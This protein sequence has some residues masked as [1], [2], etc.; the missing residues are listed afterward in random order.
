MYIIENFMYVLCV[1]VFLH[2]RE[3]YDVNVSSVKRISMLKDLELHP[4]RSMY[5]CDQPSG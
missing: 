3:K 1:H 4:S 2:N 5:R